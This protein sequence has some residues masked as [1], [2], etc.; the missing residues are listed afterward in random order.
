MALTEKE[1]SDFCLRCLECCKTLF[2]GIPVSKI[3]VDFY[4]ARGLKIHKT[5]DANFVE[6]PS[7]CPN[8][9]SFGCKIYPTRP[10]A[11]MDYDGSRHPIM[12][13]RCLW[14]KEE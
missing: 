7:D 12:K 8:L 5:G 2:F 3:A 13:D 9:T 14:N 6:I 4:K 10:E 1:K 11:C